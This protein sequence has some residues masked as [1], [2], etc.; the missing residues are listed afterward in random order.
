MLES[1]CGILCCECKYKEDVNCAGCTN[2]DK[3]FWSEECPVKSCCENKNLTHCGLCDT[4]PCEILTQF[5]YDKKQGD[6]GKRISQCE[7]WASLAL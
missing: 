4:F 2:I 3:P 5:A 6:D 1:R 7:K